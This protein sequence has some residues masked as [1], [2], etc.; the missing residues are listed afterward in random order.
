MLILSTWQPLAHST[1]FS[2]TRRALIHLLLFQNSF[3]PMEEP[4]IAGDVNIVHWD[5]SLSEDE[6]LV[7]AEDRRRLAEGPVS[8]EGTPGASASDADP[9]K[10]RAHSRQSSRDREEERRAV[11]SKT[12]EGYVNREERGDEGYRSRTGPLDEDYRSKSGRLDEGRAGKVEEGYGGRAGRVD[13]GFGGKGGKLE[14]GYGSK[15]GRLDEGYGAKSGRL[16]EGPGAK[17]GRSEK[18]DLGT[19]EVVNE[20]TLMAFLDEQ[21]QKFKELIVPLEEQ[22]NSSLRYSDASDERSGEE[23]DGYG[24][25]SVQQ[26]AYSG[27]PSREDD[28]YAPPDEGGRNGYADSGGGEFYG[29]G[30]N[31]YGQADSYSSPRGNGYSPQPAD[32]YASPRVNGYPPDSYRDSYD[33][34]PRSSRATPRGAE[35]YA[36]TPVPRVPQTEPRNRANVAGVPVPAEGGPSPLIARARGARSFREGGSGGT[37]GS[38]GARSSR[39]GSDVSIAAAGVKRATSYV[40]GG[41]SRPDLDS[42]RPPQPFLVERWVSSAA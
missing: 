37:S 31:G 13:E 25:T 41:V 32:P 16:E 30:N 21:A 34:P 12:E 3:N 33:N 6:N 4:T 19:E 38:S 28:S 42:G 22:A 15:S 10:S 2:V 24:A 5:N 40:E 8:N 11:R 23:T 17:G 29:R 18:E 39:D 26:E 9:P 36:R 14:E 35:T 1:V 27:S 20:E 7:S